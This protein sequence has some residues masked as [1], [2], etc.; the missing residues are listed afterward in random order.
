MS[1]KRVPEGVERIVQRRGKGYYLKN[2]RI[3][4]RLKVDGKW[5]GIPTEFRAGEER[6]AE[7]MLRDLEIHRAAGAEVA[8]DLGP[9]TV[10]R[11]CRLWVEE[12]KSQTAGWMN[13]ESAMRLHVL[14]AIGHLRLHE[15]RPLH[16]IQ[17][18]KRLRAKLA[19]K[20]VYNIYSTLCAFFRDACL[21]D[22][23]PRHGSPCI[24]TEHQLGPKADADPEWRGTA[25]YTRGELERLISDEVVPWDRRVLYA[26]EC[27]GGLRHGEAAG[28]P[29]RLV[30]Q[31]MEPL[32]RI[33][34]AFSYKKAPKRGIVR[35]MPIHPALAAILAEWRLTGWAQLMGRAPTEDDLVVPLPPTIWRQAGGPELARSSAI[36]YASSFR[37]FQKVCAAWKVES[38]PA[39]PETVARYLAARLTGNAP[40]GHAPASPHVI[41]AVLAAIV[42]HHRAAGL[43]SPASGK[44]E[45][46]GTITGPVEVVLRSLGTRLRQPSTELRMR[47]K[48]NSR[49][50]LRKDL[51]ALGVR[52]RRGHD[53]RRTMIS[54]S[55]SDGAI[56][57]IL[58]RGTHKAPKEVMEQYTSYEWEVLCREVV[59]FRIQRAAPAAGLS[60]LP[61]PSQHA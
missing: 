41:E 20:T 9:V 22:L 8:G 44:L 31:Q 5:K 17:I 47:S 4:F 45:A 53:L 48:T 39:S 21:A 7:A 3:Y 25:I 19:S 50:R 59:K 58:R 2:G 46:G 37:A 26:L 15:V 18:T 55:R 38:L 6:A 33:V 40:G 24:L 35:Y 1:K 60:V 28:L 32:G 12:R 29:W 42:Y 43:R 10:A 52:H 49:D 30:D 56:K 36:N 27:I 54:L 57:D 23:L 51:I 11:Y 61:A 34:V 13:D 14:P 16:L